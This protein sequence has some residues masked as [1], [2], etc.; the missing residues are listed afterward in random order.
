MKYLDTGWMICGSL[1]GRRV[2]L[3]C[4]YEI[5]LKNVHHIAGSG[6]RV[7][8]CIALKLTSELHFPSFCIHVIKN[9][10][11]CPRCV[12][13]KQSLEGFCICLPEPAAPP[14]PFPAAL[15]AAV[16]LVV[17]C[18]TSSQPHF[19]SHI[20]KFLSLCFWL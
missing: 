4:F 2:T 14:Q 10:F 8:Y 20:Q 5:I 9:R 7:I 18:F 3:A 1:C 11:K 12:A 19:R 15:T 16:L 6:S 17:L 13:E